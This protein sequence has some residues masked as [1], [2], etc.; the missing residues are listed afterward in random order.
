[1][2]IRLNFIIF[3]LLIQAS[4]KSRPRLLK[5]TNA[6]KEASLGYPVTRVNIIKVAKKGKAKDLSYIEY[7]ICKRKGYY[8]KKYPKKLKTSC[9]LS[10]FYRND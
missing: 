7:Y 4:F 1:M 5:K 6:T 8:T 2:K 9:S 10:N 3:L